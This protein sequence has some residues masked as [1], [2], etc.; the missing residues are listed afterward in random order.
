MRRDVSMAKEINVIKRG[1]QNFTLIGKAKLGQYSFKID[2]QSKKS[3][4]I[5]SQANLTL[6]TKEGEISASV[7]GG[8]NPEKDNVIYAFSKGDKDNKGQSF[9]VS[10]EDRFDKEIIETVADMKLFKA[11][12]SKKED[13]S[14]E[15]VKFLHPY[16]FISHLEQHMVDG[17]VYVVRGEL[18]YQE[19]NG[20]MQIKK[21][22][23]SVTLAKEE[24]ANDPETH[25]AKFSTTILTDSNFLGRPNKETMTVPVNAYIVDFFNKY[26]KQ[27]IVRIVNGKEKN[28]LTM[29]VPKSFD[30]KI[31]KDMETTKKLLKYLKPKRGAVTEIV[32]EGIFS[33]SQGELK[34]EE[35]TIDDL[36]D[37]IKFMVEVGA[38]TLQEA[39][40]KV[41]FVYGE[42]TPEKMLLTRPAIKKIEG[43]DG[44]STLAVN[45]TPDKYNEEDLVIEN[46]LKV[47]NAKFKSNEEDEEEDIFNEEET[48]DDDDLDLDDDWSDIF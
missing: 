48:E 12:V 31:A 45:Y 5:Y 43:K 34:G 11:G 33:K 10:W 9:T 32:M 40:G 30:F 28:G 1:Q 22:I 29:P 39:L 18:Q 47:N 19:Y 13:G 15:Y 14:I 24:I 38:Y 27:E 46:I 44:S 7:M 23:T 20:E 35:L 4:Y 17:E 2:E 6:K 36:D 3:A 26:N 25:E 8:Y 21:N 37:D 42:K 41:N 16:D